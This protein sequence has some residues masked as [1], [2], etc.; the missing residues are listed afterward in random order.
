MTKHWK[1]SNKIALHHQAPS[2][3]AHRIRKLGPQ[4]D[5]VFA[6]R[7]AA[8][9]CARGFLCTPGQPIAPE[10]PLLGGFSEGRQL[11]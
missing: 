6:L 2:P 3:S 8:L 4:G 5:A 9:L 7:P 11:R 1:F 10:D